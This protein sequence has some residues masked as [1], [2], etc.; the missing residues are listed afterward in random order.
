VDLDR[1]STPNQVVLARVERKGTLAE[2]FDEAQRRIKA[3]R[4]RSP[5]EQNPLEF[6]DT[7]LVPNMNWKVRH[8]FPE[9]LGED[10]ALK[11]DGRLW[12]MEV[13][14]Q[15]TAFRFEQAGIRIGSSSRI[16]AK[17]EIKHGPRDF[18]FNRPFLLYLKKRNSERPFFVMWVDNAELLCPS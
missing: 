10:K 3:G 5:G 15:I 1:H 7:L 12:P 9:L 16:E 11:C 6:E 4:D 13:A 2:T 18:H 14:E 17:S 8:E